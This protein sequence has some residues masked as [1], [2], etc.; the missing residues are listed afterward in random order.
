MS[1]ITRGYA[2]PPCDSIVLQSDTVS[3][4]P[5]F[6]YFK[7]AKLLPAIARSP[8][9]YNQFVNVS[10]TGNITDINATHFEHIFDLQGPA[11]GDP[12]PQ[13]LFNLTT[14]QRL[15]NVSANQPDIIRDAKYIRNKVD[16]SPYENLTQTL[17][18]KTNEQTYLLYLWLKYCRKYT[19]ARQN[20]TSD[21]KIGLISNIG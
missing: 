15:L 19:F 14:L 17:G 4:Y 11:G 16:L 7:I 13:S 18:F 20:D 10:M 1:F 6:Y 21:P 9:L 12:G 2:T 5:E 8:S 3:G